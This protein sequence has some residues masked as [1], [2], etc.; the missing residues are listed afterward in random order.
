MYLLYKDDSNSAMERPHHAN[1]R[2][3]TALHKRHYI[4]KGLESN[5]KI[6]VDDSIYV[7]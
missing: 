6:I 1:L 5:E 4:L 7:M 2:A 3:W